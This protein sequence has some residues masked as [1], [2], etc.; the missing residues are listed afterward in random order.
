MLGTGLLALAALLRRGGAV[1]MSTDLRSPAHY[2]SLLVAPAL[3][4]LAGARPERPP[5]ARARR[6]LARVRLADRALRPDPPRHRRGGD[7]ALPGPPA[8]HERDPLEQLR[9][10][11]RQGH[12]RR[13]RGGR[14]P[15]STPT[16]S[17]AASMRERLNARGLASVLRAPLGV[18][19]RLPLAEGG[20]PGELLDAVRALVRGSRGAPL[21]AALTGARARTRAPQGA[22]APPSPAEETEAAQLATGGPRERE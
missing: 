7:H 8:R 2:E 22:P 16:A 21:A 10:P 1:G 17:S 11:P 9:A 19:A 4:A 20:D 3:G 5:G 12:R 18:L 14:R 6:P 13:A 15:T